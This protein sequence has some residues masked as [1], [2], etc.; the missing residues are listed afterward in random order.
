M[1]CNRRGSLRPEE[2]LIALST[3]TAARRQ[4]TRPR[5]E[6]LAQSVDWAQLTDLLRKRRLLTLLGPR[7]GQ[8][9]PAGIDAE[10][11]VALQDALAAGRRHGAFLQL[12]GERVTGVLR[13]AGIRCTPLKGPAL[14]QSLYG[15][16][17]RRPSG[18]LDVLVA[19][20]ELYDAVQAVRGLGYASPRDHIEADGLPRLH[21]TMLHEQERLPPVELHWRIHWYERSH[22][23]ERL[24]PPEDV[25]DGDWRPRAIDELVALLLFYARD[26][27]INLRHATDLG[28]WWDAFGEAVPR[29]ALGETIA[30]YPALRPALLAA[31]TVAER[32][33]GLPAQK[34]LAE[35]DTALG[36]RARIAVR[37]ATPNPH[38]SVP[39]LYADMSLIDGLLAPA[40]GFADFV[41]RQLLP[42]REV[43]REHAAEGGRKASTP[44]GHGARMLVRYGLAMTQLLP[45][46]QCSRA[47]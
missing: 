22:A 43:L 10:F 29:G 24:L 40:G 39:Q 5:S 6:R 25:V 38:A 45:A 28:A 20:E 35:Q 32:T 11:E 17:G 27:F 16:P 2:Q 9:A 12:V 15:D 7:I 8:L 30:A 14:S 31:M 46:A 42:P 3:A 47:R 21:L 37:L 34:L 41:Q 44:L 13:A 1:R 26:G 23:G 19:R 36:V 33:V 4:S 18:D